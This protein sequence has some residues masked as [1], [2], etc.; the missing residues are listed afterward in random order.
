MAHSVLSWG[1]A[2]QQQFDQAIAEG[3]RAIAL[4]PNNADSY[5]ALAE[6]LFFAGRPAEIPPLVEK[7]MRLNPRYPFTYLEELGW[8]YC[9]TGRYAE[10]V[11][12]LKETIRRSPDMVSAYVGLASSYVQQW[13]YQQG[14]D[15][16]TLE[17]A[18][19]ITHRII[20]LNDFL[21]PG[22][23][24]LGAVYL[25][26][27]QYEPALAELE[28]AL[29]LDPNN[30]DGYALLAAVLSHLGRSQEA[31]GAAEKA[32]GL[33]PYLPDQHLYNVGAAY[34]LA[35][36]SKEAIAPLQR[37]LSRYTNILGAHLTLAAAYSELGKEA[38]A[39][40]E[41]AEVLRLNPQFSLAVHHQRMPIKDPAVLDHQIAAL[42]RAG[43]K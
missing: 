17:Q 1:Y 43:L 5:V 18:L 24:I 27:R 36:R 41:A 31:L 25:L 10:A 29:A 16:Q 6:A 14:A 32:L 21:P 9:L 22:H 19:E 2:Q 4:D 20:A 40:A 38:E 23:Q 37:Y 8:G 34:V 33:K 26:Q 11:A 35:G 42:R 3:Q 15:A 13:A 39:R 12:T 7:A 28:R 30:G